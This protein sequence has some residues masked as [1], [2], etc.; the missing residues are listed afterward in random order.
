MIPF[1]GKILFLSFWIPGI[2]GY[3]IQRP[4]RTS[5]VSQ[6][7]VRFSPIIWVPA[8]VHEEVFSACSSEFLLPIGKLSNY[9]GPLLYSSKPCSNRG[10]TFRPFR[11]QL[12]KIRLSTGLFSGK[13]RTFGQKPKGQLLSTAIPG[14][15][16][17]FFN[18]WT[19]NP[20]NR[21]LLFYSMICC[22]P[23]PFRLLTVINS[24]LPGSMPIIWLWVMKWMPRHFSTSTEIAVGM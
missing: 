22:M 19:K 3:S 9:R 1:H 13:F 5:P 12:F 6:P 18:I 4:C 15:R 2:H 17:T 20:T 7:V 14:W 24:N 21:F 10:M 11:V 23:S 8:A 16:P